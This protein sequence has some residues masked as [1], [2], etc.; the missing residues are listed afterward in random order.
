MG[1]FLWGLGLIRV[2]CWFGT[3][4]STSEIRGRRR[5]EEQGGCLA[6]RVQASFLT[7]GGARSWRGARV[8][9]TRVRA[10]SRRPLV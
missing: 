9:Y 10:L 1:L 4:N 5:S 8:A 3:G 6:L 2:E 7:S